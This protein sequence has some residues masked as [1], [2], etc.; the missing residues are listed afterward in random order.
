MLKCID[1]VAAAD[2]DVFILDGPCWAE[3]YGN[4]LVPHRKRFPRGVEPLVQHAHE[5]GLLFGMYFET[6]G[7]RDGDTSANWDAG[8]PIG[9][10][11]DTPVFKEHPEWFNRANLDLTFPEAAAYL[12]NELIRIIEH[13]KLDLYRHDSNGIVFYPPGPGG[14]QTLRSRSRFVESDSWRYY[15][16]FN[17]ILS[18]L[19]EKYPELILQE[20]SAGGFR[21]DLGAAAAFHE[22]FAGD[23]G[24]ALG[25]YRNS[26]GMSVFLPP[27]VIVMAIGLCHPSALPD[28]ETALRG[29]Y[30][31]GF[32]PMFFTT[33]LPATVEQFKPSD[34]QLYQRYA[35]LYHS[36]MRPMLSTLKV[37]HHAPVTATS[38]TDE[39]NWLAMEFASPDQTKGW[40][41]VIRLSGS[42]EP[43]YNLKLKGVDPE[44][45]YQV[46]LDN[47]GTKKNVSG[48]NLMDQG[49]SLTINMDRASELVL[50][51]AQ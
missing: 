9:L 26:S 10:W 32:T 49:L 19:Q 8:A 28:L 17:G 18:R 45:S 51:E 13:Y 25:T 23:F 50:F 20:A 21:L 12:E 5:K 42:G 31:M 40:A 47:S 22:H 34:Q 41:T 44:R 48:K 35:K 6:E 14:G 16:A 33:M 24:G 36:Y 7:G 39:G 2:L 1:V 30:T 3:G 46:T 43:V 29:G 27:E 11:K 38:G 15:E 4:W 37:Y